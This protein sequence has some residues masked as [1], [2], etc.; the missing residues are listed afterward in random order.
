MVDGSEILLTPPSKIRKTFDFYAASRTLRQLNFKAKIVDEDGYTIRDFHSEDR[1]A[2][3]PDAIYIEQTKAM[4][5]FIS[6]FDDGQFP[7]L[8]LKG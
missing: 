6:R 8:I 7:D 4:G 3:I 5:N 1:H 2:F